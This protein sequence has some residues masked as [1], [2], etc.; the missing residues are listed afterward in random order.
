MTEAEKIEIEELEKSEKNYRDS[1]NASKFE[2]C[3]IHYLIYLLQSQGKQ[4]GT[5]TINDSNERI[6]ADQVKEIEY[7]GKV[8]NALD[9]RC[10]AEEKEN[11]TLKEDIL[12][13]RKLLK[14]VL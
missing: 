11:S 2:G 4:K 3:F 8:Q 13:L 12:L 5:T 9:K 10:E 1:F 6:I 14:R 7:L